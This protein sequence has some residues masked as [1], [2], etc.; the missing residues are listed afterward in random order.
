MQFSI[1]FFIWLLIS[2]SLVGFSIWTFVILM[3]QKKSWRDFAKKHKLRYRN[4]SLMTSPKVH[5]VYKDYPISVFTGAHEAERGASNRQMTAIEVELNSRMP[6]AGAF[7]SGGMVGIV[8]ELDYSDEFVPAFDF[9]DSEHIIRVDD[10]YI[11]GQFLTDDRAKAL[12]DLMDDKKLWVIFIFKDSDTILRIDTPEPF[13]NLEKLTKII[14]QMI[15]IAQKLELKKGEH[16]RL[17]TLTTQRKSEEARVEI[18]DDELSA[19]GLEL[20]DDDDE[21]DVSI[22]NDENKT[23]NSVSD[24]SEEESKQA[25]KSD[26]KKSTSKTKK[27]SKKQ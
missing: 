25:D 10:K 6:I 8:Q 26:Q 11:I 15:E 2:L 13:D 23:D 4:A 20:E 7:A 19:I 16:N 18:D 24:G 17:K 14:D 12:C 9:W 5:G 21:S 1:W 22:D 3:R 27:S